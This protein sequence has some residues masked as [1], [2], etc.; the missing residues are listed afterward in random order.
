MAGTSRNLKFYAHFYAEDPT[1][2]HI[3]MRNTVTRSKITTRLMI[4]AW[5]I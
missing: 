5:I 4:H 2:V 1:V 3:I